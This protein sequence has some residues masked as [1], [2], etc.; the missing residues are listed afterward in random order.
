MLNFFVYGFDYLIFFRVV[1]YC[2]IEWNIGGCHYE[3]IGF[4]VVL[5]D[6]LVISFCYRVDFC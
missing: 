6:E 1:D 4:F 5:C 3:I 2:V